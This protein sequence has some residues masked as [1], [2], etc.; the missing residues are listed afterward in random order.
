MYMMHLHILISLI[1]YL[2]FY[3]YVYEIHISMNNGFVE[4]GIDIDIKDYK[5]NHCIHAICFH[6]SQKHQAGNKH[7][8]RVRVFIYRRFCNFC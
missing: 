7:H 8:S 1:I 2:H 6:I 5:G 4:F 3:V